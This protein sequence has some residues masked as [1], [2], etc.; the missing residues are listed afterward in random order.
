LRCIRRRSKPNNLANY[1]PVGSQKLANEV[2][3]LEVVSTTDDFACACE[4]HI[5]S[6]LSVRRDARR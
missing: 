3:N 5:S 4:I 1:P 2:G 6:T